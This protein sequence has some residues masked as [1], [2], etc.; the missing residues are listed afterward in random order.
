MSDSTTN[1]QTAPAPAVLGFITQPGS[2]QAAGQQPGP[3]PPGGQPVQPGVKIV[4]I[5]AVVSHFHARIS[6]L[7][8]AAKQDVSKVK[9]FVTKYWPLATGIIVAVAE[10][11]VKL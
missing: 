7:E 9:A 6:A 11:F 8:A 1:A 10:H 5:S 4:D 3:T 2:V